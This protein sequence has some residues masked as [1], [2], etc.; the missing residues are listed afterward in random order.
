MTL[1]IT[2]SSKFIMI[3]EDNIKVLRDTI[4]SLAYC[5][6]SQEEMDQL[7]NLAFA[8]LDELERQLKTLEDWV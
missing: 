8:H 5:E 7:A 6:V 4:S 3:C 2:N 1:Q